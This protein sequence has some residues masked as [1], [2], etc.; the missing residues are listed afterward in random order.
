MAWSHDYGTVANTNELL[1][2]IR[3]FLVGRGWTVAD[4]YS[5]LTVPFIAM[6]STGESGD[7]KFGIMID[8][9]PG[10]E[11]FN[12]CVFRTWQTVAPY[13]TPNPGTL[14]CYNPSGSTAYFD[15]QS[16]APSFLGSFAVGD[17]LW[18]F[19]PTTG[20]SRY[21]AAVGRMRVAAVTDTRLTLQTGSGTVLPGYWDATADPTYILTKGGPFLIGRW[22]ETAFD[23]LEPTI[24]G[25]ASSFAYFLFGDKDTL[26]VVTRIG[27]SYYG[28]YVGYVTPYHDPR[29]TTTLTE[30]TA[31]V[32]T[33]VQVADPSLFTVGGRYQL[34]N[35]VTGH[36]FRVASIAGNTLTFAAGLEGGLAT[37]V[38]YP[39]GTLCGEDLFPV[40]RATLRNYSSDNA[41][42]FPGD[43][44]TV[45][46]GDIGFHS[47][48]GQGIQHRRNAA[49]K[50]AF[51]DYFWPDMRRTQ[52]GFLPLY[53]GKTGDCRGTL[54][55]AF[56]L[57]D[58]PG[59][60]EDIMRLGGTGGPT[61]KIF[62]LYTG[63]SSYDYWHV[64]KE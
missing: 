34:I 5:L 32:S 15:A 42:T 21:R 63:S 1:G 57:K 10:Y 46:C 53:V 26:I 11:G 23:G 3:D 43:W 18:G 2:K 58:S 50:D 19:N 56:Q 64:I 61:Y 20:T 55:N 13:W 49:I 7:K 30:V 8:R 59:N 35:D 14:K 12:T 4:D 51:G 52:D 28:T 38:T 37:G 44:G 25:S 54:R 48:S 62:C 16:G 24:P 33:T 31:G 41:A 39:V 22:T 45:N 40:C 36:I 17:T 29:T 9:V 60:S 6:R 27:T 47:Y